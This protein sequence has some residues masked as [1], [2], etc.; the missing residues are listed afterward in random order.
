MLVQTSLAQIYEEC[1]Q[2]CDPD[3]LGGRAFRIECT[4]PLTMFLTKLVYFREPQITA[5]GST[6][7]GTAWRESLNLDREGRLFEN[8][9]R[10][11]VLL[12][13]VRHYLRSV[14]STFPKT[15]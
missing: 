4:S 6:N 13:Q 9:R 15:S 8:I 1:R 7:D 12:V 14:G 11:R 10:L 5:Y 2:R 3:G